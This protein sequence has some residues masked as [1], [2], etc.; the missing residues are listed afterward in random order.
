MSETEAVSSQSQPSVTQSLK[1]LL[2][3]KFFLIILI[4]FCIPGTPGWA[5]K[6]WLPTLYAN[7]LALSPSVAGPLSTLS[8]ALSSLLGVIL[9]GYISD[10]WVH[11]NIR[12]RIFTGVLGLGMISPALLL[13]GNSSSMF[14]IMLGTVLFGIGFGFFDANNMPILCQFV[15]TKYRSTAYGLMNMCGV[16]AGAGITSIIGKSLDSGHVTR[17]FNIMALSV[18]IAMFAV[19][20]LLRPKTI[21]KQ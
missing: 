18:L 12:G 10:R 3:N 14:T 5:I 17:D 20:Y 16:F 4:Y 13:I 7:D 19:G 1:K 15:S 9:G 2:T 21:D 6:N 8:I 11:R